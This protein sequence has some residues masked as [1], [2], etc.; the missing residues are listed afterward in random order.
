MIEI[1][2]FGTGE[3]TNLAIE[4]L[5]PGQNDRGDFLLPLPLTDTAAIWMLTPPTGVPPDYESI[6]TTR[7]KLTLLCGHQC[8]KKVT[9]PFSPKM[10]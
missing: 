5:T 8:R 4:A 10:Q 2:T 6:V 3:Q 1:R 9:S 7:T